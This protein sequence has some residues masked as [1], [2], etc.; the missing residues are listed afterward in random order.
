MDN[1]TAEHANGVLTVSIRGGG[2]GGSEGD[3]IA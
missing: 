2:E 3:S 1:I